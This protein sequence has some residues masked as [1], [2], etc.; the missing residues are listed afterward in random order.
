MATP[1]HSN[2]TPT[3]RSKRTAILAVHGMG[4]QRPMETV[5]GIVNAVW[6]E[7]DDRQ[8]DDRQTAERQFWTHPEPSGNDIDLPVI[9]TNSLPDSDR[10]FDFHEFYWS[11]LMTGTRAVAVLLWL[12]ELV[13]KGPRLKPGMWLLWWSSAIFLEFVI[14]SSAYLVVL[15]VR[16]KRS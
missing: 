10:T 7:E 9:A 3:P 2:R 5:R 14:L 8:E 11:H 4:I 13:G 15:S 16:P 6:L 1:Q 12:F